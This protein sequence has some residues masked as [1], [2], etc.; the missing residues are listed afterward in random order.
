MKK[1]GTAYLKIHRMP[2]WLAFLRT[3]FSRVIAAKIADIGHTLV[4]KPSVNF[5]AKRRVSAAQSLNHRCLGNAFP[6]CLVNWCGYVRIGLTG[7]AIAPYRTW[8]VVAGGSMR[9]SLALLTALSVRSIGD[10]PG[11]RIC[12]AIGI[13]SGHGSSGPN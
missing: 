4:P 1:D 12:A 6:N 7:S 8:L 13:G 5:R 9:K 11:S 10:D 2:L 3:P